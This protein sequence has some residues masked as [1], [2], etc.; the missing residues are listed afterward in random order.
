[1]NWKIVGIGLDYV[2]VIFTVLHE[3]EEQTRSCSGHFEWF[4][5][6][7]SVPVKSDLDTF[8][9]LFETNKTTW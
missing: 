3:C 4:Q 1:M 9:I 5:T 7:H 2:N 6:N 8:D